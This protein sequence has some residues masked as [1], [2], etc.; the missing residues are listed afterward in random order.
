MYLLR[1]NLNL[2][3]RKYNNYYSV[4]PSNTINEDI[5]IEL[6]LFTDLKNAE[7]YSI[8]PVRFC[9]VRNCYV[10][11]IP[12][13]KF[14]SHKKIMRFN[15]L[16]NDEIVIDPAYRNVYFGNDI[17]N[18]IDFKLYDKKEQNLKNYNKKS[19]FANPK[20]NTSKKKKISFLSDI[21]NNYNIDDIKV[22]NYCL[23][24]DNIQDYQENKNELS[25][26]YNSNHFTFLNESCKTLPSTLVSEND[27][28]VGKR[29][30]KKK[31]KYSL[32][33]KGILKIKSGPLGLFLG[34]ENSSEK[35]NVSFGIVQY[36]Y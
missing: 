3:L 27:N 7:K 2:L 12:K 29:Q 25:Y 36:S 16:I 14:P 8:L 5:K 31:K 6:K 20:K 10:F 24:T 21:D 4:Y 22:N 26:S 1:K 19:S 32:S 30:N 23:T 11:D 34:D 17:V 35:K 18:Q 33:T 15:F 28:S 13:A 9:P